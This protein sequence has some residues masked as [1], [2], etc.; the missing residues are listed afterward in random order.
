MD[1]IETGA[2]SQTRGAATTTMQLL[3]NE[4]ARRFDGTRLVLRPDPL[5]VRCSIDDLTSADG[6][7][8]RCAF[9]CSVRAIDDPSERRMLAE[10][11]LGSKSI[12]YDSDVA[13][14]FAPA[15]RDAVARVASER[16]GI[17]LVADAGRQLLTDALKA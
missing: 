4:L 15:L 7:R 16:N 1:M 5:R 2:P 3:D 12:A 13:A 14:H 11:L 9:A 10:S 17:E 8:V 6:H